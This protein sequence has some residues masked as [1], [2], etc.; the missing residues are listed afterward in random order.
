MTSTAARGD[1]SPRERLPSRGASRAHSS[2]G[3]GSFPAP[4]GPPG[5][6]RVAQLPRGEASCLPR[7]G[8]LHLRRRMPGS[9]IGAGSVA[10]TRA[11]SDAIQISDRAVI[12][13]MM[14]PRLLRLRDL[15]DEGGR[16]IRGGVVRLITF[17]SR[18]RG[19][20]TRTWGVCLLAV[21]TYFQGC[22]RKT[23]S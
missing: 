10:P 8:K 21:F 15:R 5:A 7:L 14:M 11:G 19:S 20:G 22:G 2:H 23:K 12:G 4:S 18:T 9:V 16:P 1:G 6:R 17:T 13:P 3:R